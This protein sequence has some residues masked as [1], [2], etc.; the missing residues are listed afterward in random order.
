MTTFLLSSFFLNTLSWEGFLGVL[1]VKNLPAIAGDVRDTG[2]IPRSGRSP[3]GGHGNPLQYSCLGNPMDRGACW[4]T[5][6]RVAKSQTRLKGLGTACG[7]TGFLRDVCPSLFNIGDA[8]QQQKEAS[9]W[10]WVQWQMTRCWH[11]ANANQYPGAHFTQ[12]TREN[13]FECTVN[14]RFYFRNTKWTTILYFKKSSISG[15]ASR[16]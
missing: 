6:H 12:K 1:V 4:A 10:R 13:F 14:Q 8:G 15:T 16:L 11:Q 5:T 3:G 9:M 7:R 2:W